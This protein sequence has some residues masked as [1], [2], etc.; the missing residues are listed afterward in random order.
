MQPQT[1]IL[2]YEPPSEVDRV[3]E[4]LDLAVSRLSFD[5][6]AGCKTRVLLADIANQH[7]P[8]ELDQLLPSAGQT[9]PRRLRLFRTRL[10][11]S[12]G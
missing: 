8:K 11:R 1:R 6:R 12:R 4:Q 7:N 2:R 10:E 3:L 5:T 9:G